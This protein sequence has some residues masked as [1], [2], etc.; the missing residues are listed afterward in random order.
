MSFPQSFPS[1]WTE[2]TDIS[3]SIPMAARAEKQ[4]GRGA[5]RTQLNLFTPLPVSPVGPVEEE[6]WISRLCLRAKFMPSKRN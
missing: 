5:A 2:P 3:S 1:W 6:P 4:P